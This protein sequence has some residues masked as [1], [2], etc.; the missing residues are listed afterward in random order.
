MLLMVRRIMN[1]DNTNI[2]SCAAQQLYYQHNFRQ[3]YIAAKQYVTF[4]LSRSHH[5]SYVIWCV[6]CYSI[7][8]IDPYQHSAIPVHICAMVHVV[9]FLCIFIDCVIC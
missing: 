9:A 2:S 5:M 3:C 1:R 4:P 7:V 8:D 6:A